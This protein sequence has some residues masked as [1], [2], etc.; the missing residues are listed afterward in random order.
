MPDETTDAVLLLRRFILALAVWREARGESPLGQL[1]VAQTIENRVQDP[2][3]PE[4]YELV[5]TQPWQFS[6]F[7]KD[8]PNALKFPTETDPAWA[9][10][11]AVAHAVLAAPRPFTSA[12]HYHTTGVSPAWKRDDKLVMREGAHLFY[13]L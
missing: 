5:V 8:D 13:A 6:A 2:R 9:T 4:T 12:N 3:W 7:N 11:V 10:C 1:L